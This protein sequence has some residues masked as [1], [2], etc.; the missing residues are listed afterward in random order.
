MRMEKCCH[1]H[2]EHPEYFR[3]HSNLVDTS[4]RGKSDLQM[5]NKAFQMSSSSRV[6]LRTR[7]FDV[8]GLDICTAAKS[9]PIHIDQGISAPN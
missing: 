6:G 5:S 2:T 4:T 7:T 1:L 8:V 3:G 9:G